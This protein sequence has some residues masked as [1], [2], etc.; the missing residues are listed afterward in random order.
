MAR[1]RLLGG[2]AV[3]ALA[4]GAG[5]GCNDKKDKGD[6]ATTAGTAD[7]VQ[8][9]E[10]MAKACGDKDK[11]VAD[12]IATCKETAPADISKGCAAQAIAVYDC[13]A[14]ELCGKADKVW[15]IDDLRVLAERQKKCVAERDAARAC[16]QK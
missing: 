12:M 13:Y 3:V 6:G 9:C 1:R 15:A 10:R 5:A 2:L 16:D 7:L 11:H 14:R 4:I 8:R